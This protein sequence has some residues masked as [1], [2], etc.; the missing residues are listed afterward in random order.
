MR[1]S[2]RAFDFSKAHIL[3]AVDGS[4][5]RLRTDYLDVLCAPTGCP[6]RTGRGR[7]SLYDL[8]DSGKVNI[9]GVSNQNPMQIELLK[10]FVSSLSSSTSFI[11]HHDSGMIDAGIT[12]TCKLIA[13]S[14][15]RSILDY[16]RLNQIPFTLV[17]FQYGFFDGVFLDNE[18]FPELNQTINEWQPPKGRQYRHSIGGFFATRAHAADCRT[19]TPAV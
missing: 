15:G 13:R 18:Q 17:P 2:Q 5:K 10:K 9:F 12:S 11:Q 1:H 16:C 4:L 8:Q 14:T 7:R 6:G 19:T 3:E